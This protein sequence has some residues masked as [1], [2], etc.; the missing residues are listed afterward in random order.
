MA[1]STQTIRFS[2]RENKLTGNGAAPYTAAVRSHRTVGQKELIST[3]AKMNALVSRQEILVVLDLMNAVIADALVAGNSVATD[4]FGARVSIHGGFATVEDD[5][6]GDRNSVHVRMIPGA[7]LKKDVALRARTEKIRGRK[8]VPELDSVYDHETQ[9][10]NSSVSPGRTAEI[11]GV[12]LDCDRTDEAQGVFFVDKK[13]ALARK[14]KVV[15]KMNASGV[16][17]RVPELA[18]GTY[19]LVLRKAFGG[20]IR[21]SRLTADVSVN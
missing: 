13:G 1:Q 7:A 21:E 20:E 6:S 4:L 9:S 18:G 11:K 15:H 17:F 2:L 12:N 10:V 14:A 16:T 19:G 8:P 3:M 5:Y